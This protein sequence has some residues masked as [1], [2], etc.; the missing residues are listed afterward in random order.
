MKD[1][2][3]DQAWATEADFEANNL[4]KSMK[5]EQAQR[6]FSIKDLNSIKI[7]TQEEAEKRLSK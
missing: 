2:E 1:S 7:I 3:E 4:S 5:G 6:V